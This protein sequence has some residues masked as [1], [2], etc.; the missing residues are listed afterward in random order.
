MLLLARRRPKNNFFSAPVVPIRTIEQGAGSSAVGGAP[1][2]TVSFRQTG[3]VLRVT[4]S[5][6]NNRQILLTVH[7][8]N[9][10]AQLASSDVG[11]IFNRQRADNQLLVNDGETAVIGGLTV[12]DVLPR[13]TRSRL[14]RKVWG[15]VMICV[16]S[17]RE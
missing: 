6:T 5:I 13:F 16:S 4:P 2:V 8:E 3:V 1:R 15:S 12:T 10:D 9:S 11:F 14:P 17:A 7:A